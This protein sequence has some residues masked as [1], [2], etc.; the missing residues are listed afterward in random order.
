M[1]RSTHPLSPRD[2]SLQQGCTVRVSRTDVLIFMYV[3][4][5]WGDERLELRDDI[6]CWFIKRTCHYTDEIKN[7]LITHCWIN[8]GLESVKNKMDERLSYLRYIHFGSYL[9]PWIQE[10]VQRV[11]RL[12]HRPALRLL[13]IFGL[14]KLFAHMADL[15]FV[16]LERIYIDIKS[17]FDFNFAVC[18]VEQ[19]DPWP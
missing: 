17:T 4:T 13:L 10:F 3:C 16:R 15:K 9:K 5:F 6:R 14:A 19:V 11:K 2:T 18:L 7:Y 1:W 8:T 12:S